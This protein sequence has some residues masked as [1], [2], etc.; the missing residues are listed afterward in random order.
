MDG[1]NPKEIAKYE[2]PDSARPAETTGTTRKRQNLTA[3]IT[4]ARAA[5]PLQKAFGSLDSYLWNLSL[6]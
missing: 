2:I 6:I 5:F 4:N 1:S 3:A